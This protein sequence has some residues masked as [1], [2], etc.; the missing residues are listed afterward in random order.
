MGFSFS[1]LTVFRKNNYTVVIMQ[2][3]NLGSRICTISKHQ[4]DVNV[5][6]SAVQSVHHYFSFIFPRVVITQQ[7]ALQS[8]SFLAAAV[9]L[10]D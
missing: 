3:N 8:S 1:R 10:C 9:R 6:L 4:Y 2:Y 5:F 7:T